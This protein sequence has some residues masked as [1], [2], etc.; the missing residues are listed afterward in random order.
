MSQRKLRLGRYT[1]ALPASRLAR[2]GLGIV[3]VIGGILGFLPIV[4]FW[5]IPLGIIVLSYDIAF[6][7]RLRRKGWSWWQRRSRPRRPRR[8]HGE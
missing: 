2:I 4:G 6:I 7:R 8:P 1:M 5:M 3:L